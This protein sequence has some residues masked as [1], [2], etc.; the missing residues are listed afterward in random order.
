MRLYINVLLIFLVTGLTSA[1]RH[2]MINPSASVPFSKNLLDG[3]RNGDISDYCLETLGLIVG[4]GSTITRITPRASG[5][6]Y[7][8]NTGI[9]LTFGSQKLIQ[10]T[11]ILKGDLTDWLN[12]QNKWH[13]YQHLVEY[14][15]GPDGIDKSDAIAELMEEGYL[16]RDL[17]LKGLKRHYEEF[18]DLTGLLITVDEA[19]GLITIK[20]QKSH[21]ASDDLI[22]VDEDLTE[23]DLKIFRAPKGPRLYIPPIRIPD[24]ITW[25]LNG[26]SDK[27]PL[28]RLPEDPN[29]YEFVAE[30]AKKELSLPRY[31]PGTSI[32][33]F[34]SGKMILTPAQYDNFVMEDYTGIHS[35][36]SFGRGLARFIVGWDGID[37]SV[38]LESILPAIQ[39]IERNKIPQLSSTLNTIYSLIFDE[40]E[41]SMSLL[42]FTGLDRANEGFHFGGHALLKEALKAECEAPR[43]SLDKELS[44]Y[45]RD[46]FCGCHS[47]RDGYRC[48][49]EP[50]QSLSEDIAI[51]FGPVGETM[52]RP[53]LLKA[54]VENISHHLQVPLQQIEDDLAVRMSAWEQDK[55]AS[56]KIITDAGIILDTVPPYPVPPP[57]AKPLRVLE[58]GAGSLQ[59][60]LAMANSLPVEAAQIKAITGATGAERRL[61]QH[62]NYGLNDDINISV[63]EDADLLSSVSDV[64]QGTSID[65][66]DFI[67]VNYC[68]DDSGLTAVYEN[69]SPGAVLATCSALDNDTAKFIFLQKPL[70]TTNASVANIYDLE[71][72]D[73]SLLPLE[74]LSQSGKLVL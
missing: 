50:F 52:M 16:R 10:K 63:S 14:R 49:I 30:L 34:Q 8:E 38:V 48:V 37:R 27:D 28:D 20:D 47:D 17:I 72:G 62:P 55:A 66:Y 21:R 22:G 11:R 40:E 60:T 12:S 18:E 25:K 73:L 70:D 53:T 39:S 32:I 44:Y 45:S 43:Q 1:V 64:L 4:Y 61:R 5:T 71:E 3:Y 6:S 46:Y 19:L 74:T 7:P 36:V 26:G 68:L 69:M 54:I 67:M 33:I 15:V 23:E 13:H 35:D 59:M 58:V 57:R 24:K 9:L 42:T 31:P 51:P 29:S 41:P 2:G 65:E 56:D